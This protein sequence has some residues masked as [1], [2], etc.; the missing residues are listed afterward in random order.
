MKLKIK[1]LAFG[2][3]CLN[4]IKFTSNISANEGF[5]ALFDFA[6]FFTSDIEVTSSNYV[7]D[8]KLETKKKP[9]VKF[10][11]YLCRKYQVSASIVYNN[12]ETEKFGKVEFNT[13]G[14]KCFEET[15]DLMEFEYK[16]EN[17]SFWQLVED[18]SDSVGGKNEICGWLNDAKYLTPEEIEK[19]KHMLLKSETEGEGA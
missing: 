17:D 4:F 19:I 7:I 10:V 12:L 16:Y 9:P 5:S 13:I 1:K 18:L 8:L 15:Y 6:H 14:E 11:K 3:N 2:D